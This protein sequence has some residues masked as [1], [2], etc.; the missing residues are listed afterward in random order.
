[1][2]IRILPSQLIDQIA[3]GEVV[4]RPASV[5]KELVENSLDAGRAL[6]RGRRRR[7]R[8]EPHPRHGRRLRHRARRAPARVVAAR[9]EQDR[10][11]R[12][13]R[14][15]RVDGVSRRGAAEHRFGLAAHADVARCRRRARVADRLQ[16]RRGRR[17]AAGGA[18][19]RAPR[20]RSATCSSTRRRGASSSG[21]RR[22]S[23][24]TSTPC[25]A[26]SRSR[27]STSSSGSRATDE[28]CSRY[29]PPSVATA[30]SARLAAVCGEEFMQHAR[31]FSSARSRACA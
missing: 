16:R 10:D 21:P 11:A 5:V 29:R 17:A 7:R 30:R 27:A 1:M 9:D 24:A 8:R 15:P 12:R 18:R 14:K 2:A 4:E 25:C 6:D 31:Y 3:A 19:R 28:R 13:S 26:I 22:R 20:S 23:S